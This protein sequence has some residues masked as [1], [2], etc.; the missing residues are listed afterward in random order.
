MSVVV[1]GIGNPYRGDDAAGCAVVERLRRLAPGVAEC[2]EAQVGGIRLMEA[3]AGYDKAYLVDATET[4]APPGAIHESRCLVES[5]NTASSHDG[6]LAEALEL[7]RAAGLRLPDEIRVWGIEAGSLENFQE[8][9]TPAV[10]RSVEL[11]AD[12]IARILGARAG[13]ELQ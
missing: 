1:I 7:G 13:G 6:T 10:A 11:V 5:R 12:R 2:V 3:M 8:A 4:G 9:L